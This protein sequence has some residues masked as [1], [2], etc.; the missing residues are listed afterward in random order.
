VHDR[1]TLRSE[2]EI[3]PQRSA[4]QVMDDASPEGVITN[5][6]RWVIVSEYRPDGSLMIRLHQNTWTNLMAA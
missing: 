5:T 6:G 4:R 1:L 2:T 3:I